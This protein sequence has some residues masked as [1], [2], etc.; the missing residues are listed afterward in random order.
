MDRDTS[1][2]QPP[3]SAPRSGRV[4]VHTISGSRYVVD[5]DLMQLT[6]IPARRDELD[7]DGDTPTSAPLRRDEQTLKI[8]RLYRLEVGTGAIFDFEPLGDP[9]IVAFT[10]RF[11]TEVISIDVIEAEPAPQAGGTP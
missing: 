4:L 3:G 7:T 6:R 2:E 9:R 8:L 10:R 1:H 5:L 11:S